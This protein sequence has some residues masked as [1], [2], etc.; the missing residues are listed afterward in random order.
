M[1]SIATR[2]KDDTVGKQLFFQQ[3]A[4]LQEADAR[5]EARIAKLEKTLIELQEK[6][7]PAKPV[8]VAKKDEKI[9]AKAGEDNEFYEETPEGGNDD[10]ETKKLEAIQTKITESVRQQISSANE[11]LKFQIDQTYKSRVEALEKHAERLR[12]SLR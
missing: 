9:K 4:R 10:V 5:T 2:L 7:L 8:V 11:R 6:G 12:K 1:R 3:I